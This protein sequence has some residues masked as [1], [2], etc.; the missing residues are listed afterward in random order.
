ASATTVRSL[1]LGHLI[2]LPQDLRQALAQIL[3]DQDLDRDG[4]DLGQ[5]DR[6]KYWRRKRAA[7]Q[8]NHPRL[9][10]VLEGLVSVNPDAPWR[11]IQ[12]DLGL[13]L[14]DRRQHV[15]EKRRLD[16]S[17]L[18]AYLAVWDLREGW[19]EG[20]YDGA[21]ELR[22]QDIAVTRQVALPTVQSQY[23]TCFK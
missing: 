15:G 22:L 3:L 2:Q 1:L 10:E 14:K 21:K 13:L 12:E 23:R 6:A 17:T 8:L 9:D 11:G 20:R 18:D 7:E 4:L 5:D 16:S 19:S